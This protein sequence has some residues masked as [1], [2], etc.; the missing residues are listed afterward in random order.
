MLNREAKD[1]HECTAK[2][3]GWAGALLCLAFGVTLAISATTDAGAILR[4]S[5]LAI[6]AL[7]GA[8]VTYAATW[9]IRIDDGSVSSGSVF[10]RTDTFDL[11]RISEASAERPQ[12]ISG[13][14]LLVLRDSLGNRWVLKFFGLRRS[15]ARCLRN[16]IVGY[17]QRGGVRVSDEVAAILS[18]HPVPP[19]HSGLN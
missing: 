14:P 4:I 8:G 12:D 1:S 11:T 19:G 2:L 17:L 18:A 16:V 6:L 5:E 7:I 13:A 10:H 3:T 9:S 15:G